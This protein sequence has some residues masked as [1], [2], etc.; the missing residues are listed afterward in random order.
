[1]PAAP[2]RRSSNAPIDAWASPC[3][4]SRCRRTSGRKD[5]IE[6]DYYDVDGDGRTPVV[7]VLP[8]FNGQPIVT[9]YFARYF[10][11][12]GWAAIAVD[13]ERDPLGDFEPAE[14]RASATNL[15]E[16][17]RVLD[18]VDQQPELDSGRIGMFG[19]SFGAMDA[20]MLTALDSA[21]MRSSPRWRAAISRIC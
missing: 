18:W 4:E 21:S 5:S 6:F 3:D 19:I 2:R 7:I 17:R 10:A 15:L 20:V 1:M 14:R 12:Q 11:S 8:I 9:R 16:Y 13:R